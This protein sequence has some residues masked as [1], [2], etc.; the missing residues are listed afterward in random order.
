MTNEPLR[1]KW[2]ERLAEFSR[3]QMPLIEWCAA[4]SIPLHQFYY[5]RQRLDASATARSKSQSPGWVSVNV[6][7][8]VPALRKPSGISVRLGHSVIDVTAGFDPAVL[9]AVVAA[10]EP[11]PC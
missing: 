2:G 9:R 3:S 1:E 5:W 4:R 7:E 11:S 8:P 10:L 6:V